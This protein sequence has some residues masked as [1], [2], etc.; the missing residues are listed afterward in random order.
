MI[1]ERRF[2]IGLLK[3]EAL[4][5]NRKSNQSKIV[6]MKI[7]K[8]AVIGAGNMGHQI[9]I[10]AALSGFQVNCIDTNP[11]ILNKALAFADNYLKERINYMQYKLT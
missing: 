1:Y 8:I 4:I 6:N 2:T 5:V 11:D 7:Q 9:A 10:C 3:T